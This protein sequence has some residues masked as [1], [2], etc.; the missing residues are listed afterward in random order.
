[1][2]NTFVT[3]PWTNGRPNHETG[4]GFGVRVPA[5][6]VDRFQRDWTDVTLTMDGI[7]VSVSITPGFWRS[8]RELRSKAIGQWLI[9]HGLDRWRHRSPPR[10]R[11]THRGG[12][13]FEL[14]PPAPLLQP[15]P[16]GN[17]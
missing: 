9:K 7:E 2:T 1:M 5:E 10:I 8:C 17:V 13:R 6:C 12:N 3:S 16:P 14:A 11:L 15:M 4:S